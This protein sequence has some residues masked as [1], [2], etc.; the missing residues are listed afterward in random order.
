M[1]SINSQ[2]KAY[3]ESHPYI[4]NALKNNVINYSKLTRLISNDKKIKKKDAILIACRRYYQNLKKGY[5]I[6]DILSVLENSKLSIKTKISVVII[7]P[8]V[9]PIKIIEFQNKL[10]KLHEIVHIIRGSNA[11]TIILPDEN[12]SLAESMFKDDVIKISKNLVQLEFRS[13]ARLESVPGVMAYLCSL[14]GEN[15]VNIV[16]TFSCWTDTLFIIKPEDL[17]KTV[18]I[19]SFKD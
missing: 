3:I 5:D 2:T 15:N 18:E 9:Q 13:S 16:E 7:E 14:L 17:A 12:L 1:D 19:L 6:P 11:I 8:E 10:L 4:K